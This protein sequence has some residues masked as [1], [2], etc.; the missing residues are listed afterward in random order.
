MSN[1]QMR[2]KGGSSARTLDAR[3]GRSFL[4]DYLANFANVIKNSPSAVS[5]RR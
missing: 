2:V 5:S 1:V 4:V 3:V